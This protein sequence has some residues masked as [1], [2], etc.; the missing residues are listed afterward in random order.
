MKN[1][2]IGVVGLGYVGLPVAVAFS[3]KYYVT[4]YDINSTRVNGLNKFD[5]ITLEIS[6][7]K[8]KDC[9]ENKLKISSNISDIIGCNIYIITVPTPINADKTPDL[10]PLLSV[11]IL[12]SKSFFKC[13]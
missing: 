9:L 1:I 13:S 3:K 12:I 6:H 5:D 2:K 4:G 8:L 7:D 11:V 10:T